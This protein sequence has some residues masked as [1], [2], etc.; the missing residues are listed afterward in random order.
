MGD[1]EK[2]RQILDIFRRGL[3]LSV[4]N[5]G[6]GDFVAP[7]VLADLFEGELFLRLCAEERCGGGGKVRVLSCLD[8]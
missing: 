7:D 5:R 1:V 2:G 3:C 6:G 8:C 4:E